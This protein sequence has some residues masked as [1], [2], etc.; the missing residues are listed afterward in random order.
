MISD[1]IFFDEK[2]PTGINY[3]T[4]FTVYGSFNG[5]LWSKTPEGTVK[6]YV[7]GEDIVNDLTTGGVEAPLSA[8]QGK[9]LQDGK[10][11]KAGDTMTGLLRATAG[12]NFNASGGDTLSDYEIGTW[13]PTYQPQT[14]TFESITMR[15]NANG[16]RY[17]KIGKLVY[18]SAYVQTSQLTKGTASGFVFISGLPFVVAINTTN[19]FDNSSSVMAG[20]ATGFPSDS[21]YGVASTTNTSTLILTKGTSLATVDDLT[22]ENA[23]RNQIR[24]FYSYITA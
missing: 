9:V 5:R 23:N 16:G 20:L 24:I 19:T 10:V 7:Q 14:N 8:E 11:A 18:V 1:K 4:P 6:F 12:I 21:V 17:I 15:P 3:D 13:T 22:Y 2:D